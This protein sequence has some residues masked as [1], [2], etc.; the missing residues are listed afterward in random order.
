MLDI[1]HA[2]MYL[3]SPQISSSSD[4][5]TTHDSKIVIVTAGSQNVGAGKIECTARQNT[6]IFKEIIPKVV[7]QSPDC[8]LII[9]SQPVDIMTYIAWKLSDL[10]PYRVIGAGTILDSAR[11]RYLIAQ[12]LEVEP[13]TCQA[14][15]IGEYGRK[16]VPVWSAVS[17]SGVRLREVNPNLGTDDDPEDWQEIHKQVVE[18]NIEVCKLKHAGSWG[19]ALSISRLVRAITEDL[20]ECFPISTHIK[21]CRHGV[22]KDVFLSLPCIIGS[23]GVVNI[24]RQNLSDLE[25]DM[26]QKSADYM[27][28][29]Q[30][31]LMDR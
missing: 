16:S 29:L 12:R 31:K 2:T 22:D 13:S 14:F 7:T 24:V 1:Q 3:N 15:I 18:S 21:G 27:N 4:Y 5:A 30:K 8:I 6:D 11:F 23:S 17:V 26:I 20:R 28:E 19:M 25:K 9:V 10:P